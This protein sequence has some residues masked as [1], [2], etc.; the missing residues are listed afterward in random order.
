MTGAKMVLIVGIAGQCL[1]LA[2]ADA[3][4]GMPLLDAWKTAGLVGVLLVLLGV[5]YLDGRKRQEKLERLLEENASATAKQALAG[6]RLAEATFQMSS[7]VATVV[8]DCAQARGLQ[9]A[10]P[11]VPA[12]PRPGQMS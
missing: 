8:R 3:P 12:V 9:Q 7:V 5:V 2:V 1:P 4:T 6:E 10:P 11:Q